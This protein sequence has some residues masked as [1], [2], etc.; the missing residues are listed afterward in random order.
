V[1]DA[2]LPRFEAVGAGDVVKRGT[3]MFLVLVKIDET[4]V[5]RYVPRFSGATPIT[6]EPLETAATTDLQQAQLFSA[7]PISLAGQTV[8][9]LE[10]TPPP[11]LEDWQAYAVSLWL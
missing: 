9:C 8:L 6:A 10:P 4:G 7:K 11:E 5:R 3:V 1:Q 2:L